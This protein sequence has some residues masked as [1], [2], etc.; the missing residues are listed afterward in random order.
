MA[1]DP[2]AAD[3]TARVPFSHYVA[4]LR[5]QLRPHKVRVALLAVFIL[6]GIAG[7]L[8]NPQLLR[9]FIN[10]AED[11]GEMRTLVMLACVFIG[12]SVARQFI[13]LVITKTDIFFFHSYLY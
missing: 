4:L 6:T 11:G 10:T 1:I 12:I 2:P 8:Y 3:T 9:Q 7:T 5:E 13:T